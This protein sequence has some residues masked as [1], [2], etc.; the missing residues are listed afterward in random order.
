MATNAPVIWIS[1]RPLA[2]STTS[3]THITLGNE[4]QTNTPV[5]A[6]KGVVQGYVTEESP[7]DTETNSTTDPEKGL[8]L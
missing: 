1:P 7:V 2:W 8:I 6:K 4:G 3:P 5:S